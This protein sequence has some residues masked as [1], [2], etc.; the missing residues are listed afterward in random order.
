MNKQLIAE[1]KRDEGVRLKPYLCTAGKTTIGV[2]RN[3]DDVGISEAEADI[4]LQHDIDQCVFELNATFNWYGR[5][6]DARQRVLI[7]MCFNLGLTRLLG[8]TN[9]LKAMEE[10]DYDQ[11]AIE[12]ID[13]H[14]ATQVGERAFRLEKMMIEG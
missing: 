14:W 6:T 3:L 2:G 4:L 10:R 9:F 5:Q 8:F 1:L 7:N 11:A 13:S 12:M